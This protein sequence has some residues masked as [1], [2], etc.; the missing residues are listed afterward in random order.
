MLPINNY[1]NIR[2][3]V[4]IVTLEKLKLIGDSPEDLE[5]FDDIDK[6]I[7]AQYQRHW[8]SKNRERVNALRR[9]QYKEKKLCIQL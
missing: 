6:V 9:K 8:A 2:Q 5:E 4:K 7:K 1:L 3:N